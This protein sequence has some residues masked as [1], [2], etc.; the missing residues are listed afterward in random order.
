MN[1]K[2]LIDNHRRII[3]VGAFLVLWIA[4]QLVL[5]HNGILIQ[6]DPGGNPPTPWWP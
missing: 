2:N 5:L 3:A 6:A 4:I 1:I